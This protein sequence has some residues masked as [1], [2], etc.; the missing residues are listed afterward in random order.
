MN[1]AK[2]SLLFFGMGLLLVINTLSAA[3]K[4]R[5]II[6]Q[7][8]NEYTR[9]K[10]L[11]NDAFSFKISEQNCPTLHR[12]VSDVAT[13]LH[14]ATPHIRIMKGNSFSYL[15]EKLGIYHVKNQLCTIS[16]TSNISML[17]IGEQILTGHQGS[18]GDRLYDNE[19][20]A[21]IAHELSHI[22]HNHFIKKLT[23][24]LAC[25]ALTTFLGCAKKIVP[26][27]PAEFLDGVITEINPQPTQ[28]R[29]FNSWAGIAS[30][31]SSVIGLN[32]YS[33]HCEQQADTTATTIIKNP[34]SL[35]RSLDKVRAL[36]QNQSTW[37]TWAYSWFSTHPTIGERKK[38]LE[39]IKIVNNN[40]KHERIEREKE[41]YKINKERIKNLLK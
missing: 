18:T 21:L 4:E 40:K 38:K 3:S 39:Q 23:L 34:S 20:E 24:G 31:T 17:M 19:L 35:A 8:I 12:L 27:T 22:Y 5:I 33:R 15:I 28:A 29:A 30:F 9:F 13:R 14:I 2:K 25:T 7:I 41:Q 11:Y 26:Q 16:L 36:Q 37:K 10:A 32:A 6:N 1:I